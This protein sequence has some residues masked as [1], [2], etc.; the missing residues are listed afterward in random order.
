M[1]L[2]K[3]SDE[4][5]LSEIKTRVAREREMTLSI[6]NHLREISRRRLFAQLGYS[7]LFAYATQELGYDAASAMRRIDAMRLLQEMPE[8]EEKIQQGH[9]SL[10]TAARAQSFFKKETVAPETKKEIL[11]TLENKWKFD[12]TPA[13][14]Y[15][16]NS[17]N[18]KAC[19][20]IHI[21]A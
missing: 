10:S 4:T 9:L 15:W 18:S 7:T 20:D 8:V 5:L 11:T 1:S 21:P 6:L 17:K 12:S 13:M 3:L 16:I 2:Q 19:S 14:N